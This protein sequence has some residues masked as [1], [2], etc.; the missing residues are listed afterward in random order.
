MLGGFE[1]IRSN[2]LEV[3][4]FVPCASAF[5]RH[6]QHQPDPKRCIGHCI[7]WRWPGGNVSVFNSQM[8]FSISD[9]IAGSIPFVERA[10]VQIHGSQRGTSPLASKSSESS[11][12]KSEEM[13]NL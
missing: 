11:S 12:S 5:V 1:E 13:I 10:V 9:S 6:R 3:K 2:F 8:W 4:M 7:V